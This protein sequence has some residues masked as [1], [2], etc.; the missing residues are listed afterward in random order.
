MYQ[1]QYFTGNKEF[2]ALVVEDIPQNIQGWGIRSL[3][4][5]LEIFLENQGGIF[6]AIN[7]SIVNISLQIPC[8]F[9]SSKSFAISYLQNE[10]NI[11][12]IK[13]EVYRLLWEALSVYKHSSCITW[14]ELD[15]VALDIE[16]MSNNVQRWIMGSL[17]NRMENS[18][19]NLDE[20]F[21][22][23]IFQASL[24]HHFS[25][26]NMSSQISCNYIS[27]KWSKYWYNQ[28]TWVQII[29]KI[30]QVHLVGLGVSV[31]DY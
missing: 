9:A 27:K 15:F 17:P 3:P 7:F 30:Y 29:F 19:Q 20:Y 21:R 22:D 4:T 16:E 18:L 25:I 13:H 14:N 11:Y 2:V 26:I 8:D 23:I 6:R 5:S 1:I 31:S 12:N 28:A 24:G 10:P